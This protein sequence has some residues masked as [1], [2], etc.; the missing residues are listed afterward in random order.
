M[1][2]LNLSGQDLERDDIVPKL[3]KLKT[4]LDDR[5]EIWQRISVAKRK[6]WVTSEKDPIM[7]IAYDI[8]KYLDNNFFGEDYY[9]DDT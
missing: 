1:T 4:L 6:L 2:T 3:L 5:K 8:H 7:D 9:S